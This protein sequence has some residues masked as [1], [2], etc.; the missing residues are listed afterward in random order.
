MDDVDWKVATMDQIRQDKHV[1]KGAYWDQP[2]PAPASQAR[3]PSTLQFWSFV[4]TIH[5]PFDV[6]RRRRRIY[7][8]HKNQT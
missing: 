1:G 2:R 6:R 4:P 3:R 5:T 8:P 7:F